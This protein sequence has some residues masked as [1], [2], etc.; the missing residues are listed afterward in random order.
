MFNDNIKT[1]KIV[2]FAEVHNRTSKVVIIIAL[3]CSPSF[4]NVSIII[5]YTR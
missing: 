3:K 5:D 4:A 2:T 1:S